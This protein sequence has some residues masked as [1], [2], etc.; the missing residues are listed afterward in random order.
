MQLVWGMMN[1]LQLISHSLK[2]AIIVPD[3]VYLFFDVM[4]DLINMRSQYLQDHLDDII[5]KIIP[6]GRTEDGQEQNILKNLGTFFIALIAISAVIVIA[7][8]LA[9]LIHY[10]PL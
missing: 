5:D 10:L 2:F 7:L 6:I 8:V 9:V 4:N 3:N 1:T